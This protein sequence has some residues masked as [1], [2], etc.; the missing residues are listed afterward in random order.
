MFNTTETL[1]SRKIKATVKKI[2]TE[3]IKRE[4]INY[5]DTNKKRIKQ[6]NY[7]K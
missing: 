5:K 2:R 4:V 1:I 7:H 3:L 6:K